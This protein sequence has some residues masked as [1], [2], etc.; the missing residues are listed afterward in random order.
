MTW[1]VSLL[2]LSLLSSAKPK[3]AW[4][5][6]A[7]KME[8]L[9]GC[10]PSRVCVALDLH[11]LQEPKLEPVRDSKWVDAQIKHARHLF[12]PVNVDFYVRS[13]VPLATSK[14][15]VRTREDRD[16]FLPEAKSQDG[17]DVFLVRSLADVD[18]KG[19]FIRGVHWRRRDDVQRR[20]VILSSIAESVVLAHELGHFFGLPHSRYKESIMNKSP[21]KNP[22]WVDRVFAKPEKKKIR[23]HR[24]KMLKSGRLRSRALAP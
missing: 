8:G 20:W 16:A 2:A 5:T 14:G 11:L 9:T 23:E 1:V 7:S 24:D 10:E 15:D 6:Q 19:V 12:A 22:P 4:D 17:I 13:V 21:R 3:S 18:V